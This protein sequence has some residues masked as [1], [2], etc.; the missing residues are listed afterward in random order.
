MLTE[1][2]TMH[3]QS[4]TFNREKIQESTK[5][6]TKAEEHNKWKYNRGRPDEAEKISKHKNGSGIHPNRG[7]K[8]MKKSEDSLKDLKNTKK[9][10]KIH[11]TGVPEELGE[12]CLFKDK[13]A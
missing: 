11:I 7:A 6:I 1:V 2:R 9:W 8:R 10:S 12:E 3:K 13:M 4:E 5:Q